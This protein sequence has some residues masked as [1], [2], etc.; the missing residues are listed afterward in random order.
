MDTKTIDAITKLQETHKDLYDYSQ[1]VY[2][3][4]KDKIKIICRVHGIFEQKFNNHQQGQHCPQCVKPIKSQEQAVQDLI[5]VHKGKYDYSKTIYKNT[6]TK[7]IIT[8]KIHGDFSQ[9]Y[10]HHLNGSGCQKCSNSYRPSLEESISKLNKVHNFKYDYSLLTNYI[11][12]RQKLKIICKEHGI[13]EQQYNN[14]LNGNGCKLCTKQDLWSRSKYIKHS[15]NNHNG[16]AKLYILKCY[17]ETEQFYKIGIT[18]N[19]VSE[20]YH[21]YLSMP[22][23]YDIVKILEDDVAKVWDL[24]KK[25]FNLYKDYR[26]KPN[27]PFDGSIKECFTINVDLEQVK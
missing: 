26:Y 14:H 19:E 21:S 15:I 12:N 7:I 1:V 16:K 23:Q 5:E 17:N 25:L 20:R 13:F 8:C 4:S 3:K 27:K 6:N 22:Y 24:E 18:V 2:T 10:C 11:N 9:S